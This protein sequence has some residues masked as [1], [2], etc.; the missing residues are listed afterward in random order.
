MSQSP[1]IF[2]SYSREDHEIARRFAEAFQRAGLGVWWDQTLTAGEAYDEVTEQAL[3]AARAVVVLWSKSSVAS[4]WVR[5]EAT[6][7][8]RNN[9]LVPVMIGACERPVMFELRQSAD[10]TS[11]NGDEKDPAW[12]AFLAGLIRV[13]GRDRPAAVP[14]PGAPLPIDPLPVPS[15]DPFRRVRWM[16]VV[17]VALIVGLLGAWLFLRGQDR[18]A[19]VTAASEPIAQAPDEERSIAV[20]PFRNISSDPEQEYFSD[21]LSEELLNEL[22]RVP[23]LRVIGRTSSFA[24]K[25]KDEDLRPS[26]RRWA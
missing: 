10:L 14:K 15:R 26:A 13:T 5:A 2:L 20:L 4:R 18:P 21:G 17:A 11:W 12:Q 24:F 8:D 7:A 6:I 3:K 1:D 16:L 23:Q 25:G 22:T 9:T 19:A